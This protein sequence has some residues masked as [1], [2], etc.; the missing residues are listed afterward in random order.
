M[1]RLNS[2]TFSFNTIDQSL[3]QQQD[4]GTVEGL[5]QLDPGREGEEEI[6]EAEIEE[7]EIEDGGKI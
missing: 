1:T 6:E 2:F 4:S 7:E 5:K 3:P